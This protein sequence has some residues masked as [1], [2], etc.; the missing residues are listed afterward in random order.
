MPIYHATLFF[1]QPPLGWREQYYCYSASLADA[2]TSAQSLASIR[3]SILGSG[4]SLYRVS[5]SQVGLVRASASA[6]VGGYTLPAAAMDAH[7]VAEIRVQAG[8]SGLYRRSLLLGG[9][10]VGAVESSGRV[11]QWSAA[12]AGPARTWMA[13]LA[14]PP[15]R[16]QCWGHDGPTY[17]L[18]ALAPIGTVPDSNFP[19]EQDADAAAPFGSAVLVQ[20]SGQVQVPAVNPD[21]GEA[22]SARV[23]YARWTG[24]GTPRPA[25]VNSAGSILYALGSTVVYQGSL[26]TVGGY[27]SGGTLQLRPRLYVP[28]TAAVLA[29]QSSRAVG[30]ARKDAVTGLTAS[31]AFAVGPPTAPAPNPL[32]PPLLPATPPNLSPYTT[33]VGVVPI[34]PGPVLPPPP[35][36]PPPG[37]YV[38]QAQPPRDVTLRHLGDV[39]TWMRQTV[40][41][42]S[43]GPTYTPIMIGRCLNLVDTWV[44]MLYGQQPV[45]GGT[46]G[47]LASVSAGI[48]APTAYL[49]AAVNAVDALVPPTS[50]LLVYGYSLGGIIG[51]LLYADPL[52]TKRTITLV[53]LASPLAGVPFFQAPISRFCVASDLVPDMTPLGFLAT[54]A[55]VNAAIY[56]FLTPD[57][58]APGFPACHFDF[59]THPG[60]AA[61]DTFGLPGSAAPPIELGPLTTLPV[62]SL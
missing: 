5:V 60:L 18:E 28:I 57:P 25:G 46:A 29:R 35:P 19:S 9:L 54:L 10:P 17:P 1:A 38:P 44:V 31:Q 12:V 11:W 58:A 39:G 23:S 56:H 22:P 51:E 16:L 20:V 2:L 42:Q 24:T 34:P 48:H 27:L 30:P 15:W 32:A 50:Q 41:G 36:P 21:T 4:V 6:A 52:F 43:P 26:P 45:L 62:P 59:P 53:T 13:L 7:L 40:A 47:V 49:T 33:P 8:G 14:R 37:P 61:Y 3:Y 55:F